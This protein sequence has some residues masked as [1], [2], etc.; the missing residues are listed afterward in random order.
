MISR[1]QG[2]LMEQNGC[3]AAEAFA[4][5]LDLAGGEVAVVYTIAAVVLQQ[6]DM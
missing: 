1:A 5:L 2:V 4:I 3:D 6:R